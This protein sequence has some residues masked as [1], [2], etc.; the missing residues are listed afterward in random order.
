MIVGIFD[1]R[2]FE[3][4]LVGDTKSHCCQLLKKAWKEHRKIYNADPRNYLDEL[5]DEPEE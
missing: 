4:V 2:N 1:T 3:F 5:I